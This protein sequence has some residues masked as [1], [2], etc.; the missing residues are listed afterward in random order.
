M[1]KKRWA[2]ALGAILDVNE[3]D[4][5]EGPPIQLASAEDGSGVGVAVI[6]A[7]TIERRQTGNTIGLSEE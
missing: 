2:T 1:F 4:G 7:M 3:K 5:E 6:A